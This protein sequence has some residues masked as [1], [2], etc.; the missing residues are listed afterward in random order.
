M[1]VST[2]AT[3]ASRSG[4]FEA[5]TAIRN[6]GCIFGCNWLS[7]FGGNQRDKYLRLNKVAMV[8]RSPEKAGVG[9]STPSLATILSNQLRRIAENPSATVGPCTV[10]L[11]SLLRLCRCVG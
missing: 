11:S 2:A 1:D 6:A 10:L 5:N 4:C 8:E 3:G 9:G 7:S